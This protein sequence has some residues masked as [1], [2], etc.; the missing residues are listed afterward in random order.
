MARPT[1][2]AVAG[3]LLVLACAACP[4][5]AHAA[6]AL[7]VHTPPVDAPVRDPFRAPPTPYAAGNRGIEYAVEPGTEVRASGDGVVRFAGLVAGTRHVTLAHADGLRTSYSFLATIEV[8]PG[9]R[10]ARGQVVGLSSDRLHVGARDVD[11]AYLDPARLWRGE[12]RRRARLVPGVEE[13]APP[14]IAAERA[15]LLALVVERVAAWGGAVG[16]GTRLGVD[17]LGLRPDA[18]LVAAVERL[19]TRAREQRGCT[20]TGVP[21]PVAR[22]RRVVVLV[23]GLGSTSERAAVDRVDAGALGV[24]PGDVVRFSYAGGVVPRDDARPA[25]GLP[26]TAYDAAT[27]AGDLEVAAARLEEV[28]QGL[29][30]ARPGTPIDV[31]AHSQGGVV[32]RLAIASAA[33]RGRLPTEV[34]TLATL[35]TPH[36]GADAA[37]AAAGARWGLPLAAARAVLPYDPASAAVRQLDEGSALIERLRALPLPERVH[38]VSIAARGDLVVAVPRTMGDGFPSVV[39]PLVGPDAHDRLPGAPVTTRELALAIHGRAPTCASWSALVA[40]TVVGEAIAW[41]TD[42]V[43]AAVRSG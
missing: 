24:A 30:A 34:A 15:G 4:P 38:R 37:S 11:G 36:D 8:A 39:V 10:V 33:E 40:D 41:A 16:D 19:A 29:A 22:E 12:L 28:L 25:D 32:A 42:S 3:I 27:S 2:L 17:L 5:P 1:A 23:G 9:Q 18:R 14:L 13:G 21:T 7:V 43:G 31:I 6:D 35:G 20:P 26:R